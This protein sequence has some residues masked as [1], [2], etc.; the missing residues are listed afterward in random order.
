MIKI[1]AFRLTATQ[2]QVDIEYDYG[3]EVYVETASANQNT[4]LGVDVETIKAWTVNKVA[5]FRS[6]KLQSVADAL[7]NPLIDVDLEAV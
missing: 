3:G 7:L 5:G 6:N 2:I 4:L 1:K